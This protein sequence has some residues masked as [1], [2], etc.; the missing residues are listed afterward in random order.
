[1]K[2]S[3]P[4]QYYQQ[5]SVNYNTSIDIAAFAVIAAKAIFDKYLNY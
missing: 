3:V 4:K 5:K 2:G 1:M